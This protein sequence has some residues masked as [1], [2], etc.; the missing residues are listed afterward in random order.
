M[1][2]RIL[3]YFVFLLVGSKLSA[4]PA[5]TLYKNR[6]IGVSTATA[7]TWGGSIAGLSQVWYSDF[8][9]TKLHSFDDSKQWM[10]MDKYG[11]IFSAYQLSQL[12]AHTFQ[13]TGLDRKKSA[14]IG[15]GVGWGYQLSLELLD[16]RSAAWGFSWSDLT[17]NTLGSGLF[18]AQEIAWEKQRIQ[19]KFSYSPTEYADFRPEVLG[20][21]FSERILKDYNGQTYWISVAP[22]QFF[23]NANIP[24]W[25]AV[26]IGFSADAKIYGDYNTFI[27]TDGLTKFEAKREFILSLDLRVDELPVQRKWIKRI[28]KPFDVIKVPFPAL[29]LRGNQLTGSWMYF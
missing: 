3:F 15:A 5:D 19:L 10:Q 22:T 13:W 24:N 1:C 21:T 28:L 7:L 14:W 25:I 8:P 11:H 27:T 26:A 4:A 9:K 16:G 17:A 6:L 29:I 18:L 2:A 12:S 23:P 20:S